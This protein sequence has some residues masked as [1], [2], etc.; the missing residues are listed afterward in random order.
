MNDAVLLSA[1]RTPIGKFQGALS[2]T[3]A[4][5]LGAVA[6]GAAIERAGVNAGDVEEVIMGNV[7]SAGV[8]QAP[9]RQAALRA[10]FPT[11]V[12]AVTIN[13]V[14]G[15]GLKAVMLANQAIRAGE[16]NLIVAGGLES[17]SRAPY[18]L[19]RGGPN[20]GDRRLSDAMLHDG[21][22]CAISNRSMGQIAEALARGDRIS[23]DEQD[24]YAYESHRRAVAAIERGDFADEIAPTPIVG[25]KG[26]STVAQD[27][28]PRA[29]TSVE[30]LSRLAPAFDAE[31]TVTAGN[32]SMISDG[33]AALVVASRVFAQKRGLPALGRI[34]ACATIGV[35]PTDLFIA[36]V[37]AVRV[38]LDRA[39]R[40]IDQI[41]LFEINEAFAVQMLACLRQLEIPAD[42]VNVNGGAI[43]LGHPIGASGARVLVSLTH[44]LARRKLRTGV[45]AL[46]LGGGNAVAIVIERAS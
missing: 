46:C 31:G 27:E 25:K 20:F 13:K 11:S 28:G 34:L 29:D 38:A 19:D 10:G 40:T 5:E 18:L 17:M 36:P 41:D 14:C 23:R 44:A 24:R 2:S 22:V 30:A 39:G 12:A 37:A 42:R 7:L 3:P 15:S 45:A 21:L 1:C 9:A 32:A 35:D 33:A 43:A 4:V 8:G 26:V 6:I 16:A